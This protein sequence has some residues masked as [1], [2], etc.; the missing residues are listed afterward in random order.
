M[1]PEETA[2]RKTASELIVSKK[3]L[4]RQLMTDFA[5]LRNDDRALQVMVWEQELNYH[6]E[7]NGTFANFFNIYKEGEITEAGVITRLAR[8]VR[9]ENGW[10]IPKVEEEEKVK[11]VLEYKSELF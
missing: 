11:I 9:N 8:F 2:P 5:H 6:P 3:E 10:K 7:Y 1:E 4:I